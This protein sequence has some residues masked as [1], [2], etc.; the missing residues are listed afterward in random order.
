[1]KIW[2][3]VLS[4]NE[5]RCFSQKYDTFIK[6][7]NFKNGPIFA[8][9]HLKKSAAPLKVKT[10]ILITIMVYDSCRKRLDITE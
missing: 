10:I 3:I 1:M 6:R 4:S 8:N 9:M 2:E 5:I 7:K